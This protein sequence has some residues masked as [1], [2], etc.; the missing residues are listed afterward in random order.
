MW[1]D[2]ELLQAW[3]SQ[4]E[5]VPHSRRVARPREEV[6]DFQ[7]LSPFLAAVEAPTS[8]DVQQYRLVRLQVKTLG[9]R[10]EATE[11]RQAAEFIDV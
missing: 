2:L 7:V 5:V 8:L 3:M 9:A 11:V 1:S 10:Q 4:K 6:I